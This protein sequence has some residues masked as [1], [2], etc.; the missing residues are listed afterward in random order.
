MTEELSLYDNLGYLKKAPPQAICAEMAILRILFFD[1]QAIRKAQKMLLPEEFYRN[2]NQKIYQAILSLN[3][4]GKP[5]DLITLEDE[6]RKMEE[7]EKVGGLNNLDKIFLRFSKDTPP[8]EIIEWISSKGLPDIKKDGYSPRHLETYVK[9]VREKALL[10]QLIE[11][12]HAIKE[13][14]FENRKDQ[15]PLKKSVWE[16]IKLAPKVFLWF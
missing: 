3:K 11:K 2:P 12:A 14:A 16:L 7:I 13:W 9:I 5:I 1:N 15:R 10:R 8:N 6:L 4:E